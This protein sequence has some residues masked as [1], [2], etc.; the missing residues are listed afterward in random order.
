MPPAEPAR[1]TDV[2]KPRI[3][4]TGTGA[5]CAAG[6]RPDAILDDAAR[7]ALGDRPDRGSGTRPAGR[8][9]R[10][11]RS[12]TSTRARWSTTASCTSSSAAPTCSGCTPRARAIDASGILAHRASLDEAAAAVYSDRT[13]VYVGSGGGNY[14]NQYDFFPLLTAAGG[15]LPT[16]G[17][18]LANTVN[19]M[20]LLRTLPNNVLGHIGI[21]HGLKGPNACI[22]NHS[23]GGTLAVIEAMEALRQRR[24]RPRGGGRPRCADR[25]ADGPLLPAA[26]AARHRG[27][28]AVR[29]APRRQPVR[30]RAP[31]RWCS[32]PRP[33]PPAAAR[34][35]WA[36]CWAAATPARRRACSRSATTATASRARSARRS[37]TPGSRPPTS[38]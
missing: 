2:A 8:C 22:T 9:A 23:V 21:R 12:P 15:D 17:R 13:G 31:A 30:R 18:E 24:G 10:P 33:R 32:R 34:R 1:D 38:A 14:Q 6:M 11:A 5:V 37:P 3:V 29:R 36:K 16:F 19:P 28:A 26:G 4:V 27:A 7:R 25:A 35:C 20:W